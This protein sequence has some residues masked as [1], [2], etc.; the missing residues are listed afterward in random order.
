VAF[1]Q[2]PTGQIENIRCLEKRTTITHSC[3]YL[4]W[5]IN[6]LII[7]TT[8]PPKSANSPTEVAKRRP[9]AW[10]RVA[11]V[12]QVTVGEIKVAQKAER[13]AKRL[14][15]NAKQKMNQDLWS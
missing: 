7:N 9:Q 11:V 12:T 13:E 3:C 5:R 1:V 2:A 4:S 10:E 15:R 14:E 6:S 8:P